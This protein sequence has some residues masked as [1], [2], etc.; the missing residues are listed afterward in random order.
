[1]S[2]GDE[3]RRPPAPETPL[4]PPGAPIED[5]RS[6]LT[7]DQAEGDQVAFVR[8]GEVDTLG[9]ITDTD[10]YEGEMEAGVHDDLPSEPKAENLEL[11]T[12]RELR[13]GETNNPDVAAEEGLAWVPPTDPPVVPS[14]D[15]E[16]L[17]VAAGFGSTSMDEPYDMDHASGAVSDEDETSARVR[18]ALRADASTSRY[19]D[20]IAIGTRGGVVAL[21]GVVDD[22]YDT[23]NLVEVASRVTGVT[24]A[25]DELEVRGLDEVEG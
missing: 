12:E 11:L 14:D 5:D 15:R 17:D 19:A 9:E 4:N 16:G 20:S 13:A 25:V 24:E 6:Q 2:R 10:I 7:G 8:E 18:E 21:R 1:V 3:T 23:D 22:L